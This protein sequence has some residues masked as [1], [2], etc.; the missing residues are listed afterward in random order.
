MQPPIYS[1]PSPLTCEGYWDLPSKSKK[2]HQ[3]SPSPY[4]WPEK[5]RWLYKLKT[6]EDYLR[7]IQVI[8]HNDKYHTGYVSY[9]GLSPSRLVKNE[10][11]GNGEYYDRDYDNM[12]WPEGYGSYYIGKHNVMPTARFY[13]Y[14]NYRYYFLLND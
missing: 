4:F 12:C 5:D 11:V 6:I 1:S 14:V 3:P 13:N 10:M 8:I 7:S 2:G 9:R